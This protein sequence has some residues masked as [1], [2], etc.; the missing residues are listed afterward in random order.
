MQE[1]QTLTFLRPNFLRATFPIIQYCGL[2]GQRFYPKGRCTIPYFRH[3]QLSYNRCKF[4]YLFLTF[5][6]KV[7]AILRH[8]CIIGHVQSPFWTED[9]YVCCL[10]PPCIDKQSHG[11][12]CLYVFYIFLFICSCLQH[13]FPKQISFGTFNLILSYQFTY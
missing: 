7:G 3:K 4:F 5:Y 13:F 12:S 8:S 1:Q 2:C 10:S 6:H 9:T 11:L